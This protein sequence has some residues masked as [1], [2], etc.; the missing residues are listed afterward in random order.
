MWCLSRSVG[1]AGLRAIAPGRSVAPTVIR[2]MADS[3]RVVLWHLKW[4]VMTKWAF[5]HG[6]RITTERGLG[7]N[8]A[9]L[10][11]MIHNKRSTKPRTTRLQRR[12][13]VPSRTQCH[14]RMCVLSNTKRVIWSLTN[15]RATFKPTAV[16][17]MPLQPSVSHLRQCAIQC[18]TVLAWLQV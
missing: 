5:C 15:A 6:S 18:M 17:E 1:G 7:R 13:D 2:R 8:R 16:D 3:S 14:V 10:A 4:V 11:R 12:N 9:P